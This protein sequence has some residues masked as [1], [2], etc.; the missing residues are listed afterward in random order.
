[1]TVKENWKSY[2]SKPSDIVDIIRYFVDDY[3][4]CKEIYDVNECGIDD[5]TW[6]HVDSVKEERD[7]LESKIQHL[8]EALH[9]RNN[10]YNELYTMYR[11]LE[12]QVKTGKKPVKKLGK[13]K[14]IDVK[15]FCG[16]DDDDIP[17]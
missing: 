6:V 3:E 1:M 13:K 11:Q 14:K 4:E 15:G 16:I 2:V 9:N 5:A 17:F 12:K 7:E 8:E 10:E